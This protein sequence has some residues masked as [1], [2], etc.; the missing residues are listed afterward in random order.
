M[1]NERW[2][3]L[4]AAFDAALEVEGEARELLLRRL[5]EQDPELQ[6]GVKRLLALELEAGA[7]L[8]GPAILGSLGQTA[9]ET[10]DL[11]GARIGPYRIVRLLG[12]GG[13]GQVYLA[14]RADDQ[15]EKRVA[16]KILAGPG[17]PGL[18]RRFRT[19]RQILARFEHP[20]IARL[21]DGGVAEDGRLYLVLEYVDGMPIDRFCREN[22]LSL[23]KRLRLFLDVCTAVTY[24]HQQLIV[25]RDLKPANILVTDDGTPKLLDFGIAKVLD[26]GQFPHQPTQ[27]HV[28]QRPLTLQYASPEQVTGGAITTATDV[29]GLGL[30]LYELVAGGSPFPV[31]DLSTGEA[32][33]RICHAEPPPASVLLAERA[34]EKVAENG[35]AERLPIQPH[36][37]KGDLDHILAKALDKAPSRR[38]SSIRHFAE[39]LERHLERRPISAGAGGWL[40]RATRFMQRQALAVGLVSALFA[41]LIG[42]LWMQSLHGRELARERDEAQAARDRAEQV[43]RYLREV[44]SSADPEAARGNPPTARELLEKGANQ[45]L[46]ELDDDPALQSEL[47]LIMAD[48]HAGLG[49]HTEAIE[50]YQTA[51][52]RLQRLLGPT[53]PK[54]AETSAALGDLWWWRGDDARAEAFLREAL[55][56]RSASLGPRHPD[57]LE[58]M[59]DLAQ[60]RVEQ[61]RYEEAEVLFEQALHLQE[62]VLGPTHLATLRTRIH[63]GLLWADVGDRARAAETLRQALPILRQALGEDHPEVA[64]ALHN[65]GGLEGDP[66]EAERRLTQALEIRRRIYDDDDPRTAKTRS[67]L[68]VILT[69]LKDSR[70]MALAQ[71]E[72][73]LRR[74]RLGAD[75][76]QIAHALAILGEA[77]Y[78]AG[79]I[80]EGLATY[81]E[82]IA[83]VEKSLGPDHPKTAYPVSRLGN[84]LV[85]QGRVGEAEPLLRRA[86]TIREQAMDPDAPLLLRSK[87]DLEECLSKGGRRTTD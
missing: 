83:Q 16:I 3:E 85:E 2:Q 56:L 57:T 40:Y 36:Q 47:M 73:S 34:A 28:G 67:N 49:L 1:A 38:Y 45:A 55:T 64:T 68:V 22:R 29:Y 24:A 11:K 32:E 62:E 30:L 60:H 74:R 33:R 7:L 15:F 17:T 59:A 14:E 21:I 54:I 42:F 70:A 35:W 81:R 18:L 41:V 84:L 6:R 71:E 80:E 76:P 39:D 58:S 44:F 87:A 72:L 37:L 43:A 86:V 79:R 66:K 61:G 20:W 8:S 82:S 4:D 53:H 31:G 9:S 25:H 5:G 27:T 75:H 69:R 78:Q 12:R 19:E 65:L 23:E 10:S 52:G 13:M 63:L 48:T 77:L 50:L 51:R 26:P 46:A